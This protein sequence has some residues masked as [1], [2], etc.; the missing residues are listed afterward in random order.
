MESGAFSKIL[1]VYVFVHQ[2]LDSRHVWVW[3]HMKYRL[4]SVFISL[5][6]LCMC[7]SGGYIYIGLLT[8]TRA[9]IMKKQYAASSIIQKIM[10]GEE[11]RIR[12]GVGKHKQRTVRHTFVALIFKKTKTKMTFFFFHCICVNRLESV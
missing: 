8:R 6:L 12:R 3:R 11:V 1:F 4:I 5:F 9:R 2:V 7:L 10:R